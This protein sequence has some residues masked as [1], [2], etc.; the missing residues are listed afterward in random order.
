MRRRILIIALL[1]ASYACKEEPQELLR[2]DAGSK[3]FD[4]GQPPVSVDAGAQDLGFPDAGPP[5]RVLGRRGLFGDSPVANRVLDPNF[6]L[7]SRGWTSI[8]IPLNG[9]PQLAE[10]SVQY[11][12]KTPTQ[13]PLLWL[14]GPGPLATVVTLGSVKAGGPMT[15]SLWLGRSLNAGISPARATVLGVGA[16]GASVAVDLTED[17]QSVVEMGDFVW[18]RY[19]A[20]MLQPT[21]G[22]L[23]LLASDESG[24]SFALTGVVAQ[25]ISQARLRGLSAPGAIARPLSVPQRRALAALR[26]KLRSELGA[27]LAP[28]ASPIP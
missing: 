15:V 3:P 4:A 28:T 22:W 16:D 9:Q 19:T 27:R 14:P 12:P 7:R 13:Q 24:G 21:V 6:D 10:V 11:R 17:P 25:P 23:S 1:C 2:P 5:P 8:T 18:I 20:M 26:A